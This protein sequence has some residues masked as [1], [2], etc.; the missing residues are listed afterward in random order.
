M[1]L[2][3]SPFQILKIQIHHQSTKILHHSFTIKNL[4]IT[5]VHKTSQNV[6]SFSYVNH[7]GEIKA[8]LSSDAC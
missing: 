5:T 3:C 1:T 7:D 8:N 2:K 4:R 6:V